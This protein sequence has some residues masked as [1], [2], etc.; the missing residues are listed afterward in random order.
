MAMRPSISRQIRF[1]LPLTLTSLLTVVTH[2]FFNAGLARLPSPE[3]YL[4]AFAVAKSLMHLFESPIMMV[5][6]TVAALVEHG[7]SYRK[8]RAF[9]IALVVTVALFF[10]AIVASGLGRWILAE[11]MGLRGETLDAAER[12]LAVFV[13]FP[14]AATL[15][16][17]V[18]GILIKLQ[19]TPL[20]TAATVIRIV[21]VALFVS[22]MDRMTMLP[23]PFLAG[24][25]FLSAISVEAVALFA[26]SKFA[27]RNPAQRFDRRFRERDI[28][29]KAVH[30]TFP[31]IFYFFGPLI[32]TSLIKTL[33]QPFINTGLARTGQPE[34]ALAAYAVAWGLGMIVLSPTMMFH[35]VPLA[36]VDDKR[37]ERA[38]AVRNFAA[39]LGALL[40]LILVGL[41]FSTLGHWILI[42]W[43]GAG[44]A[45]SGLAVDVLRAMAVLPPIMIAREFYW[46]L[47]MKRRTT[48]YLGKGKVVN[49][50]ALVCG[51][52]AAVMIGPQNP[53]LVGIAG[54]VSA[55]GA[56]AVYLYAA[57]KRYERS[58]A[59]AAEAASW[60]KAPANG[61]T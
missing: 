60:Q 26:M 9:T 8:V 27:A 38:K 7:Q 28:T 51:L 1:Y 34:L 41:S 35:Q 6:H 25:M 3:M 43:I 30:L 46:G 5:R 22:F 11:V 39:G 57:T 48:S 15:R 44:E 56:E 59:A 42:H 37:P 10:A 31:L 13:V 16:N 54:M 12:I 33:A 52:L 49:L 29:A 2:S 17:F 50:V 40:S 14:L 47:L 45:I 36:F 20:L 18:Q 4:A 19:A 61:R 55:E 58:Q 53:A 32:I 21:Y 23:A 24:F